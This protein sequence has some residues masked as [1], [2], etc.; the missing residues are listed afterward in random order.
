[1]IYF[2]SKNFTVLCNCNRFLYMWPTW[3]SNLDYYNKGIIEQKVW[4]SLT[5]FPRGP[6]GPAGPELPCSPLSPGSP[7]FPCRVVVHVI[8]IL[9]YRIMNVHKKL[10]KQT[11]G[12]ALPAS[13]ERPCWSVM[14]LMNMK[15]LKVWQILGTYF[16]SMLHDFSRLS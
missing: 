12:P 11:F 14:T 15:H 7:W 9:K 5:S 16:T 4:C 8:S 2:L 1:M 13:P 3:I 10:T 6:G